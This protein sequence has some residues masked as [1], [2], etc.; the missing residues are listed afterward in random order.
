MAISPTNS[1]FWRTAFKVARS[2]P[3]GTVDRPPRKEHPRQSEGRNAEFADGA[4]CAETAKERHGFFRAGGFT[5]VFSGFSGHSAASAFLRLRAV[6]MF[7]GHLRP[8]L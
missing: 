6:R 1:P 3:A 8:G 2:E 7:L 4:D 5:L